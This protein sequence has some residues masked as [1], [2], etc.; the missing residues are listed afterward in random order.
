MF[1]SITSDT[2]YGDSP[3]FSK[4]FETPKPLDRRLALQNRPGSL[5]DNS[6][7]WKVFERQDEALHF[8]QDRGNGLQTFVFHAAGSGTRQ[9]LVAHPREFWLYDQLKE[10]QQRCSYEIIPEFKPCKIYLDLEF[11]RE[12]NPTSNGPEMVE[13]FIKVIAGYIK[14]QLSVVVTRAEI[15]DLDSTTAKKFSRHLIFQ[16]RLCI[17]PNNYMVGALVKDTC[18]IIRN[19]EEHLSERYEVSSEEVQRLF[20]KNRHGKKVL[21]C[22]EAVYT[23]NRHFRL[24]RSSKPHKN[25]PLVPSDENQFR[26]LSKDPKMTEELIFLASLLTHVETYIIDTATLEKFEVDHF[27]RIEMEMEGV[28]SWVYFENSRCI[29]Y[30][31][32]GPAFCGNVGRR[33]Q[34]NKSMLVVNMHQMHYYRKCHDPDCRGYQSEPKPLPNSLKTVLEHPECSKEQRQELRDILEMLESSDNIFCDE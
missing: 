31:S 30:D 29:V 21:F 26:P 8:A 18:D 32:R 20:V 12:L 1:N 27:A 10:P 23:K 19:W 2:F 14:Q 22:D 15:L 28:R 24:Y 6:R 33:H 5:L 25:A 3:K 34:S 4:Q 7:T 11:D 13:T 16:S 17:F 9:F